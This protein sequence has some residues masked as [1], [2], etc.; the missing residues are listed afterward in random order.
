MSKKHSSKFFRAYFASP[1]K[2]DPEQPSRVPDRPVG[3]KEVVTATGGAAMAAL[4][5]A[6]QGDA[7]RISLLAVPEDA[8]G[9]RD[10]HDA[11]VGTL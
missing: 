3:P 5:V 2:A 4:S 11:G 8:V 6:V 1:N 9:F 10:V 7:D